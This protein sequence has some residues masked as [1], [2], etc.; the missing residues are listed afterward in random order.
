MKSRKDWAKTLM[1]APNAETSGVRNVLVRRVLR[2]AC[3]AKLGS[4]SYADVYKVCGD[5]R[6]SRCA[7]LKVT[8]SGGTDGEVRTLDIIKRVLVPPFDEHVLRVY[9]SYKLGQT[10]DVAILTTLLQPYD[11]RVKTLDD[12]VGRSMIRDADELAVLLIQIF[13]TLDFLHKKAKD[14][15]HMDLHLQNIAI[16][17]WPEK[18]FE[19]LPAD[20]SHAWQLPQKRFWPVLIDFGQSYT[21]EVHNDD[22]WGPGTDQNGMCFSPKFDIVKLLMELSKLL[23]KPSGA[24]TLM[25][26]L[27]MFLYDAEK[28]FPLKKPY[29]DTRY[30]SPE[31]KGCVQLADIQYADVLRY[32]YFSKFKKRL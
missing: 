18:L 13:Q 29:W 5:A 16:S 8:Y 9:K 24:A 26:N 23:P 27:C 25:R 3:T 19:V 1:D 15:V 32:A 6:C 22:L 21:T 11:A 17:P 4:G 20:A 2:D 30:G 7:A 31:A 28:P 14:F 10:T 12:I